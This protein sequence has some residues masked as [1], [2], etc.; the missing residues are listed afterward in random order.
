[1][2]DWLPENASTF[3]ADID[4]LFAVIYYF[5]TG[6]LLL[7]LLALAVFLILY[8]QRPGRRAAYITGNTRLELI[9]TGATLMFLVVLIFLSRPLWATIKEKPLPD[10][11]AITALVRG[12]QFNWVV[13]YAGPDRQ[14]GTAD[15]VQVENEIHVPVDTDVWLSLASEDVIHSF[16]V[17]HLR[18]KQDAV[19][20]REI[21]IWFRAI[22]P[23]SYEIACAELCGFGHGTMRGWLHVLTPEDYEAWQ[24]ERWPVNTGEAVP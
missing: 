1:M 14:L 8:R 4:N 9:W 10:T 22:K 7:V 3:G 12:N 13:L 11:S 24:N 23:G 21:P 17:P 16:F 5:T 20:G 18:L 2:L 6:I 15:D 19:P